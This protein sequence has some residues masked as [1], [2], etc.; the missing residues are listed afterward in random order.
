MP[1][2]SDSPSLQINIP[3]LSL[4]IPQNLKEVQTELK[5]VSQHAD[6]V[7]SRTT[8]VAVASALA[9]SVLVVGWFLS[10]LLA[11]YTQRLLVRAHLEE[12][13]AAFIGSMVRYIFFLMV[14][15]LALRMLGIGSTTFIAV[16]GAA[17]VA[18][19]F[20]LRGT[21]SHLAAGIMLVVNRPFKVGDYIE[22]DK[23]SEA[24]TVKRITLFNTE[25]NTLSN[26]RVFLPNSK[27]WETVLYNHTY[28]NVR[29][30]ED[31]ITIGFEHS[32][33]K[34]MSQMQKVFALDE[35]I[36]KTPEPFTGIDSLGENGVVYVFRVWVKSAQYSTVRYNLLEDLRQALAKNGMKIATP[37][38]TIYVH[39]EN[40]APSTKKKA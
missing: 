27:I 37:A 1:A 38:R 11:T 6:R 13:F 10:T 21:V 32:G 25:I 4:A 15:V 5:T 29:M 23:S 30:F 19:A 14:V 24:G 9:L 22:L 8:D 36:L 35:N 12:T 33:R 40:D 7:L 34:V 28:N 3:S 17:G 31:K 39:T 2:P 20:A 26:V 18:V 16:F